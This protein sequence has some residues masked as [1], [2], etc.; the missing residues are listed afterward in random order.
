MSSP[1]DLTGTRLGRY[2][3]AKHLATGGMAEI[4]LAHHEAD[5][6]FHKELVLKILQPRLAEHPAVV[7]MF[8]GEAR[9]AAA[10]SHP[11]IVDVHDVAFEEGLH[12]IVMEY[13][14]G[15][16]LTQLARRALE[17]SHNLPL[18]VGTHIVSEVASALAYMDEG[19]GPD[20]QR[21]QIVHR[22][23]S[24]TN[25]LIANSGH[26]KLIDF[27]IARQGSA[28]KDEAGLRPGKAS[29]MSPEQALGLAIDGRSDIFCLGTILYEITLGRRLWRGPREKAI[30]RIVEEVPPPPTY[31]EREYPPELEQIVLRTLEK[32]PEDRYQSAGDLAADLQEFLQSAGALMRSHHQMRRYLRDL[33]SEEADAYI[34]EHGMERARAFVEGDDD[35]V[36]DF[37]RLL[38]DGPGAALARAL[39]AHGVHPAVAA[40]Q[41]MP[42]TGLTPEPADPVDAT[43]AGPEGEGGPQ[44]RAS[45]TSQT[46]PKRSAR[47]R[48]ARS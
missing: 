24:P 15:V 1:K 17:V 35:D 27:G 42:P 3:L 16:T 19:V 20:G 31:V 8:L 41:D 37:D 45:R 43:V 2:L 21:F 38:D 25:I 48:N 7:A 14:P 22:D 28:V 4:F 23:V 39:R 9:I 47:H 5:G 46:E 29:Y 32:R 11:N 18:D 36:L 40:V 26:I 10:L 13:I 44:A 30:R 34:S 12:Y 6:G 33:Y